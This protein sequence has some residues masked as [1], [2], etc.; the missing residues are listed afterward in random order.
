[1]ELKGFRRSLKEHDIVITEKKQIA[2]LFNSYFVNIADGVPEITEQIYGKGFDTHP[3]IQAIFNNN[4]QIAART[5][6]AFQYTNKT[7]VEALLLKINSRKSCGYDG[8][9]PR[10]LKESANAIAG[11]I[12]AIMNHSIRTGQYPSRLKLGQVTPLFKKDDELKKS[13]YR[14]VTVLPALNNVFERL[15]SAQM[16]DFYQNILSD[17]ISAYRRHHSCE[18]SLLRLTEDWKRSLDNKE[19]VAVISMDLS[20]A[21]DTIPHAL[22]LAKL[23]A[24]GLHESS[25][26]LIGDYLTDRMQRVKI[27]DTYSDWM[28][29]KRGVP[30]GSV[31]G[32]MFFN[33]FL[34]DLI[35]HIKAVKLNTYA[36]DCQ[37]HSSDVD[38]VALE[39]RINHD[40][41]I[42]NKWFE[43]N[44]MKANPAKHQGMVLG[45]TDY[46]FSF[47][48]TRCLQ[49]FGITLDNELNFKDH[50]SSVCKKINNQFS[51][52]KRFGKLI[53]CEIMLRLYKA[54]ILPHFHYCSMIW[55]FCNS[56]DSV[57]L[58][59]LNRRILRFVFKDWDSNYDT[60][61]D[62]AGVC[63]LANRRIKN[64]MI[65]IFKCLHFGKYP[66]YL[67][68]LIKLRSTAYSLRGTNIL[69]LP[70]PSTTT[71][72][73]NSF[74]YSSV[75]YWN[76]LPD[77]FRKTVD[78]SEF[79][80]KL[81]VHS[82]S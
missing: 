70:K 27:G 16:G 22:L 73:L 36:D 56:E 26:A 42:A 33:M 29:V 34:N 2:E 32:P 58:D 17:Y 10:L 63:G 35:F 31:L 5:D 69:S 1:M 55:H 7:Q 71:Y 66:C 77:H 51:V 45:K 65:C 13:N 68:Q 40:V 12:A 20:K 38:P 30:Q 14:P 19:I 9:P 37:L 44:G 25:C 39:R 4:E 3:S 57:K 49:L 75:K 24:Y 61:L 46:P 23:K 62:K 72:G 59:T 67:K 8:I 41:Q 79:K 81:L 50:I 74:S 47:S 64:M 60:L 76:S 52:F 15:L 80:R 6:F 48:T 28:S 53:S 21:F 54:F 18:T 78:Y 43:D 11:P 82:F